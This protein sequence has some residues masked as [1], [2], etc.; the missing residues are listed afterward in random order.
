VF[1]PFIL[2]PFITWIIAQSAKFSLAALKGR[3]DPKLFYA[4]GGMPS[5]HSAVVASLAVTILLREGMASPLF[6]FAAVFAAIVMYDSLGVRRASGEHA[7]AINMLISSLAAGKVKMEVPTLKLREAMGH[8]PSE[9]AVGAL[10]GA[11]IAALFHTDRLDR[12]LDWLSA[13]PGRTEWIVYT[14]IFAALVM[15]GIGYHV[16]SK[17]RFKDSRIMQ[18]LSKDILVKTQTIGWIGLV[19]SFGIYQDLPFLSWRVWPILLFI[20][21]AIWDGFLVK[22]YWKSVPAELAAEADAARKR[23]WLEASSRK[24]KRKR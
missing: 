15:G 10:L 20:A 19:L 12:Q 5:A 13:V 11:F 8:K 17:K 1:N 16:Y 9:V 7:A 4:S 23:R 3:L 24:K 22:R 18:R 14:A 6:G 21:L 2:I